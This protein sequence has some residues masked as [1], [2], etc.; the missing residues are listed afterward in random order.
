M[1]ATDVLLLLQLPLPVASLSVDREPAQTLV[2]P[3]IDAGEGL[4][5]TEVVRE[6]PVGKT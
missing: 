2:P 1:V 4:T 6:Q 3:V 5:V